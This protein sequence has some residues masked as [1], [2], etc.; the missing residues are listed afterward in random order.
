MRYLLLLLAVPF[1]GCD[2]D[3]VAQDAT[4]KYGTSFGFCAGY[5]YTELSINDQTAILIRTSRESDK[6]EQRIE[7]SLT[8]DEVNQLL[9]LLDP[10]VFYALPAVIGCPDC[11]DGGAEFLEV[12]HEG[13]THLVTFQFRQSPEGLEAFLN[14]VREIHNEMVPEN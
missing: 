10:D 13:K 6:P 8:K 7:R 9:A 4:I 5:C 3:L 2:E 12:T 11:A 14:N 1:L